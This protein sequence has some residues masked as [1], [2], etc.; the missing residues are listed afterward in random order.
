MLFGS[1]SLKRRRHGQ[2]GWQGKLYS[3]IR[4]SF[5]QWTDNLGYVV[6]LNG[7]ICIV[8]D[9]YFSGA[10]DVKV[11]QVTSYASSNRLFENPVIP[12]LF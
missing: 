4:H 5:M 8:M 6:V 7:E 12:P 2:K 11:Q 1:A 10:S 9:E 3:A